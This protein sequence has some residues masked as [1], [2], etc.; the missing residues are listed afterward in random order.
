MFNLKKAVFL[1]LSIVLFTLPIYTCSGTPV[2]TFSDGD[3]VGN[4]SFFVRD[5]S[6]NP[7]NGAKV[8]SQ[9]SPENQFKVTGITNYDGMVLFNGIKAGNYEFQISRFDYEPQT[10]DVVVTAGVNNTVTVTLQKS[11][12][13]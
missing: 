11:A 10:I 8:V 12:T 1:L 13:Y 7:L 2:S 3:M 9:N 5:E 6:G 4:L